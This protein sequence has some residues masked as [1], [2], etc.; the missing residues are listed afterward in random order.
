MQAGERRHSSRCAE[1]VHAVS[2]QARKGRQRRRREGG[3]HGIDFRDH[4]LEDTRGVTMQP[5][6]RS[7]RVTT[8]TG[9]EVQALM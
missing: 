7:D 5:P 3:Q 6:W 2:D 1:Q 4:G 9:S 8:P